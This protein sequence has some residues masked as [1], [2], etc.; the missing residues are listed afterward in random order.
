MDRGEPGGLPSMG[1]QELDMTEWL[2]LI[3][4][5]QKPHRTSQGAFCTLTLPLLPHILP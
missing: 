2:S 1:S 5:H 3:H 4:T